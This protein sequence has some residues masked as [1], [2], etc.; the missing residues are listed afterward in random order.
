[1]KRSI[2]FDLPYWPSLLICHKLD[3]MHIEK[4]ICDNLVSTLLNIEGKTKDIV[5]TRLDLQD[6]KIRKDL[7]LIEVDNRLLKSHASYMLTSSN[8]LLFVTS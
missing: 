8:E 4:N 7:H 2:F 6:L 5:D 1:M 3:I